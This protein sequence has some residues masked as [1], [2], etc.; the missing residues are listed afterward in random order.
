MING[1]VSTAFSKQNL[2]LER[3]ILVNERNTRRFGTSEVDDR[4]GF[5]ATMRQL[6]M[7]ADSISLSTFGRF[8]Q[9]TVPLLQF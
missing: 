7:L 1:R 3:T 8:D 9:V 2:L 4:P 6:D 5:T